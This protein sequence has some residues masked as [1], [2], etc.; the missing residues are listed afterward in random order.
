MINSMTSFPDPRFAGKKAQNKPS[1]FKTAL[2]G[3]LLA[4]A[5]AGASLTGPKNANDKNALTQNSLSLDH[6][7]LPLALS[8]AAQTNWDALILAD[9][10]DSFDGSD[11][12]KNDLE[13]GPTNRKLLNKKHP[14]SSFRIRRWFSPVRPVQPRL[15][16]E[17]NAQSA[18]NASSLTPLNY[19]LFSQVTFPNT[20]PM[21]PA[22]LTP[23]TEA[24]IKAQLVPFLNKITGG[25]RTKNNQAL[26]VF[27]DPMLKAKAPDAKI[28]AALA[29]IKA[30]GFDSVINA[31]KS[32]LFSVIKFNTIP[33]DSAIAYSVKLDGETQQQIWLDP[34]SQGEDWK[35]FIKTLIH[36]ANHQ[37]T[38]VDNAE[39]LIASGI[40]DITH[41]KVILAEPS[42]VTQGTK[43][44]RRINTQLLSRI[45]TRGNNGELK[46]INST[47]PTGLPWGSFAGLFDIN[48]PED[49]KASP[50]N[51]LLASLLRTF[52]GKT[53]RN[54][55]FDWNTIQL[56]DQNQKYL[57]YS[58]LLQ[59]A[60]L[61]QLN[62]AT[63]SRFKSLDEVAE[64]PAIA[65]SIA[66]FEAPASA[67]A[68][69][70]SDDQAMAPA[71]E[72]ATSD[73]NTR[74]LSRRL[75]AAVGLGAGFL[76]LG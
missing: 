75:M 63:P 16:S 9:P 10:Q 44:T 29:S 21:T 40:A 37:D 41:G 5:G 56:L 69:G 57:S 71:P 67:P 1:V 70:P 72:A 61:L 34:R 66:E 38:N 30:L 25:N 27:N 39:E 43:L 65:P 32:N 49:V 76:G 73:A 45:V 20:S 60:K 24:E 11:S 48:K 35:L 12:P 62:V 14:H 26:A 59:A 8:K 47:K 54:P 13:E 31:Y 19:E 4:S 58:E 42:L 74:K 18:W 6:A 28:R 51:P 15:L 55:N 7:H 53:V 17:K 3:S 68:P 23:Y 46:L 52:T 2:V 36:E 22:P 33:F 50:G 64:G